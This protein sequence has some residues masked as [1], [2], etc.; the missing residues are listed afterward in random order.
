MPFIVAHEQ[1]IYSDSETM[2][3]ERS[4]GVKSRL[5]A[6]RDMVARVRLSTCIREKSQ[7]C[8]MGGYRCATRHSEDRSS[9]IHLLPGEIQ[10][11]LSI[12]IFP[13]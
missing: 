12:R 3:R 8:V 4:D 13:G 11:A 7:F 9:L 1:A 10:A 2:H 5:E 6:G